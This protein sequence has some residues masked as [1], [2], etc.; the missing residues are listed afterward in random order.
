[1][2]EIGCGS[3]QI[4]SAQ[5]L[6]II[7]FF[8]LSMSSGDLGDRDRRAM[9]LFE[10]A[11]EK[12]L[13]GLM[14]DAVRYYREAFKINDHIDLLYRQ[15]KVPKAIQK[16]TNEHG[17]NAGR[18]V[19]EDAV[20]RIDVDRLLAS[21]A[22]E[23]AHAPD[24]NNPDHQDE[25]HMVVKLSNLGLDN[26]SYVEEA[27]PVSPLV[28]LPRE[29][30]TAILDILIT[31]DPELWF[32]F[33][34]TCKK[35]AYLAF[36]SSVLWSRLCHLIYP[37]QVYEENRGYQGKD[38]PVPKDPLLM[39]PQYGNSWKK[40]LRERPF[41]KF[42]GCYISVVNYYSEGARE[43][44]STTWKNPVRTV[45]YYRYLRFYPDGKCVMALTALEPGK[46]IPQFLR[47]NKLKCILAN[48][49]KDIGHINVAKEPHKIFHGSWTISAGG[50]VYVKVEE[51][52]VAYCTFHYRFQIKSMGSVPNHAKLG[53]INFFAVYKDMGEGDDREGEVVEFSLK[54]ETSFKFL[55]VRSYTLDN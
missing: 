48:P 28:H 35:H 30:W 50:E 15:Q 49:E 18:K 20:N 31:T 7:Y 44:F 46:V 13:H 52:S 39:L 36:G 41:V 42:L 54:N 5:Y 47:T 11:M 29:L 33:G 12:E 22:H 9:D 43:E 16:L 27:K 17:K 6:H 38:L 24:P 14:S 8:A 55:R 3:V 51:G 23:E 4:D 21:F 37:R 10:K 19:D 26:H 53:W 45:T 25:N 40:M 1:M 34:V 2:T 32:R